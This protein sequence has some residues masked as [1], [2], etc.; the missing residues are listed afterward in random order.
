MHDGP[1]SGLES[2]G[3]STTKRHM[4][5][6]HLA[7][8]PSHGTGYAQSIRQVMYM[9]LKGRWVPPRPPDRP[10]TGES[11]KLKAHGNEKSLGRGNLT[12]DFRCRQASQAKRPRP[13]LFCLF[14]GSSDTPVWLGRAALPLALLLA[15]AGAGKMDEYC[16]LPAPPE[17]P[18]EDMGR[19]DGPDNIGA[20]SV[21]GRC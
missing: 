2:V 3:P 18:V 10:C 19:W 12:A 9:I 7:T 21:L 11:I 5:F 14:G 17:P 15:A 1:C 16:F 6:L 20:H 4:C 13:N 8:T